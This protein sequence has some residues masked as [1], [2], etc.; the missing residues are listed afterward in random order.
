[1]RASRSEK[2]ARR[3]CSRVAVQGMCDEE[4]MRARIARL[5]HRTLA[6]QRRHSCP[7][8]PRDAQSTQIQFSEASFYD[9]GHAFASVLS[10]ATCRTCGLRCLERCAEQ[11]TCGCQRLPH[12]PRELALVCCQL[13]HVPVMCLLCVTTFGDGDNVVTFE[14]RLRAPWRISSKQLKLVRGC[15]GAS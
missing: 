2:K 5:N 15:A 7:D 1:M 10:S 14:M 11:A 13:V 8:V 4:E 9:C 6:R 3:V 12:M